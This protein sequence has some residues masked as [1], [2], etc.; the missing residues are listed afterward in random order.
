[1]N[2]ALLT[3][4]VPVRSP[5]YMWEAPTSSS[6]TRCAAGASGGFFAAWSSSI[7]KPAGRVTGGAAAKRN[8]LFGLPGAN[9]VAAFLETST[10][11]HDDQGQRLGDR[12]ALTRVVEGFG[13]KDI[14][15]ALQ[16]WWM[17]F[18]AQLGTRRPGR[19][20][21]RVPRFS[22]ATLSASGRPA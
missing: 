21:V 8:L 7:S 3:S 6:E 4:E 13:A 16:N 10:V 5:G 9:L 2:N 11:I 22:D 17:D 19:A 20:P 15:P 12:F 14:V 18:L 1:M